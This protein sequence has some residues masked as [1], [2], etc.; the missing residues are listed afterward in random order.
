MLGRGRSCLIHD[1]SRAIGC[2]LL[3]CVTVA[4]IVLIGAVAWAAV[5]LLVLVLAICR[6][7]TRDDKPEADDAA[8]SLAKP[9]AGGVREEADGGLDRR[10]A[11]E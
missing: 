8:E 1:A 7:A 5:T 6:A 11:P 3:V 10:S 4:T 9:V 2:P